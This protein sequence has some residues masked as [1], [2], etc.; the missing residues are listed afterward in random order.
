VSHLHWSNNPLFTV[1]TNNILANTKLVTVQLRTTYRYMYVRAIQ[2]N[3]TCEVRLSMSCMI[4]RHVSVPLSRTVQVQYIVLVP[5]P[6][7]HTAGKYVQATSTNSSS[8]SA[9]DPLT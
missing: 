5:L 9:V 4:G 3:S 7:H 6:D 2:F 1:A 8:S